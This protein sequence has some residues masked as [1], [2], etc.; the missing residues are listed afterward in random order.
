MLP[1]HNSP[2]KNNSR[3]Y[4][5]LRIGLFGG[6]FNPPHAGH[7]HAAKT[8][9][10]ALGLHQ[11]WWMVSPGNPF[12]KNQNTLPYTERLAACEAL[13][14][15]HNPA[16]RVSALEGELGVHLTADT[17]EE[18]KQRFPNVEFVFI[19]GADILHELPKWHKWQNLI[20]S[21]PFCFVGRPPLNRLIKRALWTARPDIQIN[22]LNQGIGRNAPLA[23][24]Q[25]Y[26]I[27]QNEMMALSSTEIRHNIAVQNGFFLHQTG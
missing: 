17:I 26:Y 23:A 3:F 12:K 15:A 8:A 22:V 24:G 13:I 6:S 10:R 5:G 19:A 20:K 7:L 21:I 9:M 18:L 25:V 14:G 2:R 1:N 4:K 16:M 11:V 27:W